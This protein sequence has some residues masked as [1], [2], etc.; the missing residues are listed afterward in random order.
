VIRSPLTLS[1]ITVIATFLSGCTGTKYESPS[2]TAITSQ[3]AFEIRDYPQMTLVSTPMQSHGEDGSFMK[4]F[5]FIQGR[6]DR[7]EKIAMTT[8]VIVT[9]SAAGTMSFV[10]PK[11]VAEMGAPSPSNPNVSIIVTPPARYA[12]YRFSGSSGIKNSEA[13]A[14]KL[15]AWVRSHHYA[16]VG[17]PTFAYYNPPWT[18]GFMRRNEVLIHLEKTD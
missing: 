9:G 1:F 17:T 13:A 15:L 6:N 7:G 2:Y 5:L 16:T 12:C 4:L 14:Q 11:K 3:G 10:L 8:P 18:P